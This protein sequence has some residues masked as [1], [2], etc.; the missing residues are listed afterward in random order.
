M[1]NIW[2]L[3]I[4]AIVASM[5]LSACGTAE[6]TPV[7]EESQPTPEVIYETVEVPVEVGLKDVPRERTLVYTFYGQ[8]GTWT[9]Y[10]IGNPYAVGFTH[11]N[12]DA[13]AL[14]PL[15]YYSAFADEYLPWLASGHEYN[16]DNTE[17]TVFLRPEAKWSDGE[18]FDCEDIKFTI[19]MLKEYAPALRNSQI[20]NELVADVEIKDPQ[21]CVFKF[22]KPTPRFY[23][24][25]LT[26]KF[27]Y[28]IFWVPEHIFKDVEDVTTFKFFDPEKGWPVVTGPYKYTV[29]TNMQKWMDRRDDWWAL[30]AGIAKLPQVERLVVIPWVDQDKTAQLVI[31]NTVD[32]GM[33][34]GPGLIQEIKAANPNVITHTPDMPLGYICH[35]TTAMG[36]N[37]SEPPFDNPDIRRAISYALDREKVIEFGYEG[38]GEDT[39][40]FLPHFPALMPFIE[41][42][43]DIMD[44]YPTNEFNLEKSAELMEI[45]GYEKDSEGFWTKDG[46]RFKFTLNTWAVFSDIGPVIAEVLRDGGYEV[47]WVST[48]DVNDV[49]MQGQPNTA[50]ISGHWG[51]IAND[52]LLSM[53]VY[54]SRYFQPTGTPAWPGI[55]RYNNA[56]YSAILD[57]MSTVPMGDPRVMELWHDAMSI[58]I[59]DLP[60]IPLVQWI[61]RIPM[62]TTYWTGWP[63]EDDPYVN[64]AFWQ[65]TAPLVLQHLEPT[66][67]DPRNP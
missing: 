39:E 27:D 23:F 28:G 36:F 53:D 40:L 51:S 37:I 32:I 67:P 58:W 16:A 60:S 18:A 12:G 46:E 66:M 24:D 4:L 52:P 47:D 48:T 59:R 65:L 63:T 9:D 43:Q 54:H 38:A 25:Y 31:N 22:T 26:F 13:V 5:I 34:L 6:P 33:D 11:Q 30:D 20:V 56:Y 15:E 55:W 50:F 10:G 45:N 21:T 35:W 8:L 42:A 1:K 3:V 17:L 7:V 62:N 49:M 57:E 14:E 19:N 29:F 41:N 2:R 61:H 64:G 44:E